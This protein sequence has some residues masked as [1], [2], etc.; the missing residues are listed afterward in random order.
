[1]SVHGHLITKI[2]YNASSLSF[3]SDDM[4]LH[5]LD[6][7]GIDI[8]G[9]LNS[10]CCG[11]FEIYKQDWLDF[12]KYWNN[13]GRKEFT[14]GMMHRIYFDNNGKR[15]G[16]GPCVS[17]YSKDEKNV[18]LKKAE[19]I[20]DVIDADFIIASHTDCPDYVRYRCF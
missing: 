2:E 11:E 12:K 13:T 14:A 8:F 7:Y 9:P 19:L 17:E 18:E 10:D 20:I 15:F 16:G 1:M 3:G 6:R 4:F 5:F